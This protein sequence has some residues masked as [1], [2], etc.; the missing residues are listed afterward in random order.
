M[1]EV[2]GHGHI[3]TTGIDARLSD[4]RLSQAV[5]T[6]LLPVGASRSAGIFRL[7]RL[8]IMTELVIFGSL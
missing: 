2:L 6:D 8:G 5:L 1:Q 4:G 3:T 7:N